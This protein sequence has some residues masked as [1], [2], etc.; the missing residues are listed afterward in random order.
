MTNRCPSCSQPGGERSNPQAEARRG[1]PAS[2]NASELDGN[3][4]AGVGGSHSS[5]EGPNPHGAKG[6][7]CERA[8]IRAERIRLAIGPL[9]KL[10]ASAGMDAEQ[11]TAWECSQ[12]SPAVAG[13]IRTSGSTRGSSG[14]GQPPPAALYSQQ[15]CG[16]IDRGRGNAAQ[17][18]SIR[19]LSLHL[20]ALGVLERS[21]RWEE[22]GGRG[23]AEILKS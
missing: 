8:T 13:E 23:K 10:Y 4:T 3:A 21:G 14:F 17:S 22:C 6:L 1:E 5:G 16:E 7:C 2:R 20:R 15:L 19:T 9:R 18:P 11:A 12:E